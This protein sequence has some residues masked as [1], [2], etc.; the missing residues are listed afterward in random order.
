MPG[1]KGSHGLVFITPQDAV[2]TVFWTAGSCMLESYLYQPGPALEPNTPIGGSSPQITLTQ[3]LAPVVKGIQ[4]QYKRI[5]SACPSISRDD[6]GPTNAGITATTVGGGNSVASTQ[7][8]ANSIA[9]KAGCPART[10]TRVNTQSYPSAPTMAID[11]NRTYSATVVTTAGTFIIAL[12]AMGAPITVNNFVFLADRGFYHC[13]IFH[14]V[15]PG[16]MDQTG[17]P[18]GTGTGG[19]GYTIPDENPPAAAD[20]ADQY[21]LGSVAMANT[22]QPNTGGSQF[23]SWP[24]RKANHYPTPMPSS[25]TSPRE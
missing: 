1:V 11:P 17:D 20:P 13:V 10:S 2:V 18:T 12:D 16:F 25:E 24:A 22:G 3:A 6:T 23:S 14:R 19:P 7:A 9:V 21:P 8:V 15:I 4:S 5:G